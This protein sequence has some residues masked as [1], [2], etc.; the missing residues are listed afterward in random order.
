MPDCGCLMQSLESPVNSGSTVIQVANQ[1]VL[2]KKSP[3]INVNKT[4]L[5][6]ER[7]MKNTHRHNTP[8]SSHLP[9]P[10]F[11]KSQLQHKW[12]SSVIKDYFVAMNSL[13]LIPQFRHKLQLAQEKNGRVAGST[14]T[15]TK[16]LDRMPSRSY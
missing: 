7:E 8:K 9:N 4:R 14:L 2:L 3:K 6:L 10:R 15:K 11:S 16:L 5:L 13:D 12:V 1:V